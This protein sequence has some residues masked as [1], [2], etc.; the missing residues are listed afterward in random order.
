VQTLREL[1][2]VKDDDK[3][4]RDAAHR[5]I[6]LR[7][8]TMRLQRKCRQ[9]KKPTAIVSQSPYRRMVQY[10]GGLSDVELQA[11]AERGSGTILPETCQ[12]IE[13]SPTVAE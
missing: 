6:Q 9:E 12:S 7:I 4:R 13:A 11:I 8:A 10:L 3:L 2:R 1:L 5:I